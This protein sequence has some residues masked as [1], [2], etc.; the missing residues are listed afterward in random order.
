MSNP[1]MEV[2]DY[3]RPPEK[4]F[5]RW[6]DDG[7]VIEWRDGETICYREELMDF[8][9][10]LSQEGFSSLGSILLVISACREKPDTLS[11]DGGFLYNRVLDYYE[12]NRSVLKGLKEKTVAAVRFLQLVVALPI[13]LRSG[14]NRTWLLYTI[15]KNVDYKISKEVAAGFLGVFNS[16]KLDHFIFK[17]G[18]PGKTAA[19]FNE[20]MKWLQRALE[21][22]P[23]ASD[24][25]L[26]I[27]TGLKNLPNAADLEVPKQETG[28][29]LK[30]LEQDPKTTGLAQ[31]TQRLIAALNIPMHAHGSSDQLF[32]GVSD[33]TNRGNFDRLLL[34]ELAHD[35]LSLMARLANNEALYLRRE[36]LPSNPEKQRILLIDTTIKMWGLPRVFAVSAALACARN[37]KAKAKIRSYALL[38][39]S[40]NEIDLTTRD[41]VIHSLEQLDAALHCG[42]ALTLFMSQQVVRED[43]E[44]FLIT[45][46]EVIHNG[47]FQSILA[48]LKKP[49][50]FLVTVNRSGQLQ[51][52]EFIKGR[53]KLL[54]EAKFDLQELL[55]NTNKKEKIPQKARTLM[56]VPAIM[57]HTPCPLYFPAS[58]IKF[59]AECFFELKKDQLACVTIDQRVLYWDSKT[60][61]AR[62]IIEFLE[63]GRFCFGSDGASIIYIL[64]YAGVTK[65]ARLYEV[66]LEFYSVEITKLP[67]TLTQITEMVFD[68]GHF[69]IKANGNLFSVD[70]PTGKV[71]PGKDMV[72]IFNDVVERYKKGF[73]NL[74]YFKRHINDGYTTINTVKTVYV[75][76]D[77]ELGFD[78]RHISFRLN[79]AMII[80]DHNRQEQN[81]NRRIHPAKE[82]DVPAMDIPN[83]NLK[84]SKFVWEDGSEVIADSRGLLH[85]RSSDK[86][87]PEITIVMIMGKPTACWASDGR[88]CGP[89]YF[90]GVDTGES[91]D[92][93]GFYY[94]YMQRFIDTVKKHGANT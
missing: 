69:Y 55:F 85:L 73:T 37:N 1:W 30:Q 76:Y 4:Y 92:V 23:S 42:R 21:V 20:D 52:Y 72:S 18:L 59:N 7:N 80:I 11:A 32:G 78:D 81:K 61:G 9:T 86:S 36:E 44:V 77:G 84:F 70:A 68:A 19:I 34:S 24:L 43:D 6:A 48:S 57:Q 51:F 50:N 5:W 12:Q 79:S 66:N 83:A 67:E 31:L 29:L 14:T 64:V 22:F 91:R 88:V 56:N 75:N 54:S 8:L 47:L 49:V 3:F 13:E 10:H 65:F 41:G 33:I 53:R 93:T 45:E 35:D 40:A 46:E 71:F 27:R 63:P 17:D 74:N 60:R 15:F 82:V 62:E 26:A 94:N 28:D 38:G 16:G 89:A 90:T 39:N 87:I 58:K 2:V 25:E